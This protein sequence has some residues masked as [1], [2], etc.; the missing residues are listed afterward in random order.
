MRHSNPGDVVTMAKANLAFKWDIVVMPK[1]PA[2]RT[3]IVQGPSSASIAQS[4]NLDLAWEWLKWW[5]GTDVRRFATREELAL[6]ARKSTAQDFLKLPA[7]P[8]NR[9]ALLDSSA[10]AKNQPYIPQYDEMTKIINAEW[11]AALTQNTKSV[12]D[13]TESAKRQI[14]ALLAGG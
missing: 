10:F 12:K 3:T 13:A 2:R 11:D 5:T 8:A 7:P 4:K 9:K 1:G 14:D 6:G